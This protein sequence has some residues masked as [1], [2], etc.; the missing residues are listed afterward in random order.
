M[1]KTKTKT[2][3]DYEAVVR[4]TNRDGDVLA[5]VGASCASVPGESLGW[6]IEQQLIVPKGASDGE[7]Q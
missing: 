5:E 1:T 7:A 3:A 2:G 4:L 6:L